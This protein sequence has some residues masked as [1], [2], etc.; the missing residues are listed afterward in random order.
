MLM[1]QKSFIPP[2][3]THTHTDV[4]RYAGMKLILIFPYA[5]LTM[6]RCAILSVHANV[7][8]SRMCCAGIRAGWRAA[9]EETLE[10]TIF[11]SMFDRQ[12]L[13]K[14]TL[15]CLNV[16]VMGFLLW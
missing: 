16:R 8:E 13:T 2:K 3:H 4:R 14:L 5:V 7:Q 11:S 1:N 10:E 15:W 6:N 12:G 9:L